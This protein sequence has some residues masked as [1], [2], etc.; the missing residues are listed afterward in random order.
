M[1]ATKRFNHA[2]AL[3]LV[4]VSSVLIVSMFFAF[5][6]GGITARCFI[7]HSATVPMLSVWVCRWMPCALIGVIAFIVGTVI[8][9]ARRPSAPAVVWFLTAELIYLLCMVFLYALAIALDCL[10][11]FGMF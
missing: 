6:V 9:R 4:P 8:L 5:L 2:A 11:K 1:S 10:C 7:P 3:I